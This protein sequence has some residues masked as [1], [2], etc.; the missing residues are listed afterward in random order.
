MRII[1]WSSSLT[2]ESADQKAEEAGLPAMTQAG[3]PTFLVVSKETLFRDA[4]VLSV[5]YVLSERSRGI[6]SKADLAHMKPSA[7]FVNTSRGP[8]VVEQDL[9]EVLEKNGIRGA[10]LDVFDLEPLAPKSRWRS[11]AWGSKVSNIFNQ[12]GK[13][14]IE[15]QLFE[16]FLKGSSLL[17][18][19]TLL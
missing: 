6:V 12:K 19:Q 10:A 1:A 3:E 13:Y 5:H 9:L 2:Q 17:R 14:Q 8:L 4:D 16:R 11:T 18:T 15:H 7:L